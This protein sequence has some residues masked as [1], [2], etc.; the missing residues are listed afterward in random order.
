[1]AADFSTKVLEWHPLD[2]M[3]VSRLQEIQDDITR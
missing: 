3:L 1:M 2:N